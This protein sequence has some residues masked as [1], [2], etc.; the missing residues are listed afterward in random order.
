MG[1]SIKHDIEDARNNDS[2]HPLTLKSHSGRPIAIL[3]FPVPISLISS[4]RNS[5]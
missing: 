3:S 1:A 4:I 2:P 5:G